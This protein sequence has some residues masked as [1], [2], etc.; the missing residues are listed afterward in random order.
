MSLR[1]KTILITGAGRGIG[2][3][4]ARDLG[5]QGARIGVHYL[6]EDDAARATCDAIRAAGGQAEPFQADLSSVAAC[7]FLVNRT[8]ERF[9]RLDV[10]INNAGLDPG[11]MSLFE[12]TEERYDQVMNVN[13]KGAFFCAQAAA[14]LMIDQGGPGRIVNISSIHARVTLAGRSVYVSSKGGVDA[15]TRAMAMD[16]A[17]HGITVNA[18]APGFIEVERSIHVIPGYDRQ[19]VGQSLP[20]GRVGFPKDISALAAFLASDE[21]SFIT[22]QVIVSDGGT[23]T[24]MNFRI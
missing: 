2:E 17:P 8:V 7:R 6:N 9:G 4:L 10:L 23:T 19:A 14:R 18:I 5:A 12:V 24:R 1:D 3:G 22:G 16:L 21:S 13:L 11:L 20:I 15:M